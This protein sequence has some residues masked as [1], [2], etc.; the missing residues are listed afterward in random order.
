MKI[1]GP[2]SV[3]KTGQTKKTDK[4]GGARGAGF[5]S[6]MR[7]ANDGGDDASVDDL[8]GVAGGAALGSIDALLA[9]QGVDEVDATNPD[10]KRRNQAAA[11]RGEDLLNRLDQIRVGLLTGQISSAGLMQLQAALQARGTEAADPKLR[12]VLEDIEL[13]VAVELAKH[14]QTSR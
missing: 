13:R 7:G 6:A 1:D 5:S 4:A 10:G 8:P 3:G 11:A 9:L 14:Q 12:S 2:G